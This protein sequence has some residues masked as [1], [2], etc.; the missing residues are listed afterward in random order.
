M[1]SQDPAKSRGTDKYG[2]LIIMLTVFHKA[3]HNGNQEELNHLMEKHQLS[4]D[5]AKLCMDLYQLA[6]Q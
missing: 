3:I 4:A 6:D 1:P 2:N 5:K